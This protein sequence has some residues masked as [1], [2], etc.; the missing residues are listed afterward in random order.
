MIPWMIVLLVGATVT[1]VMLVHLV[2]LFG[3]T[4][5]RN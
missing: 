4:T 2:N 1:L 5:G 3:V